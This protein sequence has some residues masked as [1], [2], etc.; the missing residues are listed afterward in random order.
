[1][2]LMMKLHN[3]FRP[4]FAA[5]TNIS[6]IDS[7]SNVTRPLH[8]RYVGYTPSNTQALDIHVDILAFCVRVKR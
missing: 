8:D 3:P 7:Y 2:V 4:H 5:I 6:V 1:M